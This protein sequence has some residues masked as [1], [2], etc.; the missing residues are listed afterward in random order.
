MSEQKTTVTADEA[1]T[2]TDENGN[3]NV[4]TT[5]FFFSIILFKDWH[6]SRFHPLFILFSNL[7]GFTLKAELKMPMCPEDI[8]SNNGQLCPKESHSINLELRTILPRVMSIHGRQM[9]AEYANR[10]QV[11][12]NPYEDGDDGGP[13]EESPILDDG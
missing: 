11:G 7:D 9:A 8:R 12:G 6:F 3:V 5:L 4:N 10:Q 1:M 2:E 13:E